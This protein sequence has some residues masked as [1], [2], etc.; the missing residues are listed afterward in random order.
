MTPTV[1]LCLVLQL[2][3][4]VGSCDSTFERAYQDSGLPLLETLEAYERL[5]VSLH[6]SGPLMLWLAERHPEALDRL[7]MLVDAERV[8]IVGGG[9]YAPILPLLPRR[10]RV[11]QV[12]GYRGWLERNFG[13]APLGAWVPEGVWEASLVADL[14]AAGTA[15]TVLED[16]HFHAAGLGETPLR[17]Y[18]VSEYEGAVLRV[19]PGSEQLRHLIRGGAVQAAIDHC[20]QFAQ[21]FPGSVLSVAVDAAALIGPGAAEPRGAA[22]GSLRSFLDAVVENANWLQGITLAEAVRRTPPQ[23]K[24]HLP[25]SCPRELARGALEPT[26]QAAYDAVT[27]PWQRLPQWDEIRPWVRGGSW[28]NFAVKYTE[29]GEMH[30]YMLHVSQRLQIATSAGADGGELAVARDHL[31]R[32]QCGSAYW[33]GETGG[34]Y[35]PQLRAAVYHHLIQADTCIAQALAQVGQGDAQ[36]Q[37]FVE[38]TAGDFDF[39]LTQE[40]RLANDRLALWL[41]PSRG[42]RMYQWDLR[43]IAHNLLATMQ[44]RREGSHGRPAAVDPPAPDRAARK[45][46]LDHFY[47]LDATVQQV[48]RGEVLERGD[49][50]ELPFEAKIRRASDRV[51]LQ[52]R[53][54][55]IAWGFPITITKAI[56]LAVASDEFT[57]TYLLENLP[58][59]RE[60]HFAV[61]L[62]FAGLAADAEDRFF[63]GHEG[64]RLGHLG[65]RLDLSDCEGLGVTDQAL[66][67]ALDL[68]LSRRGG[69]WAFPVQTVHAA[70][71]HA[72]ERQP[73]AGPA[74]PIHQGVCVMPHWRVRGD[75][76]GRWAVQMN[77]RA[78]TSQGL[79]P[80]AGPIAA[81]ASSLESSS[82]H[83]AAL[84][85]AR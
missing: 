40:V 2:H 59:G 72:A 31:Y 18:H 35:Q 6:L 30:A 55:G 17:G 57:V 79:G 42:G 3:Q 45:S 4:P 11:G 23:G 44:R 10:D 33:H 62:N 20:W 1:H 64:T 34:I 77:L 84:L 75:A 22:G 28:R 70:E 38:A 9:Q 56:T 60:L 66:G 41:A 39:D 80:V 78:M 48:A 21:A 85:A 67:L 8:E 69:I 12:R 68:T 54:D 49:F 13:A 83:R 32:G 52:M 76:A 50:V 63:S 14:A 27:G 71:G 53:R 61:E 36:D 25:E 29:A 26:A 58:A 5:A 82:P 24:V 81:M 15:Y 74:A 46:L 37:T 16:A 73:G 51:Q 19:F 7:R 47:D 65:T 43:L